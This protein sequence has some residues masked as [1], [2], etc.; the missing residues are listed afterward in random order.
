MSGDKTLGKS[1]RITKNASY[2]CF[3]ITFKNGQINIPIYFNNIFILFL[4]QN[5]P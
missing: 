2:L 1:E 3:L 4:T 5:L